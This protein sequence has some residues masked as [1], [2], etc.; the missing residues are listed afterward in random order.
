MN[1]F[2]LTAALALLAAP[3][4]LATGTAANTSISNQAFLDLNDGVNST[5]V[6]SNTVLVN[7]TQVYGLSITPDG[8]TTTPGQTTTAFPSTNAVLT[9]TVTNSGN[10]T[11]TLNLAASAANAAGGTGTVQ[12]VYVDT[13]GNGTY[14]P[15]TDSIATSVTLTAD[16]SKVVFILYTMPAATVAG[17]SYQ[18]NLTGTSAGDATKTDSNNVGQIIANRVVDLT[19]ISTQ[20]KTVAAGGSVSFTDTLTNTGNGPLTSAEVLLAVTQT[21]TDKNGVALTGTPFTVS[22]TATGPAGTFTNASAQSAVQSAIGAGGLPANG[23]VTLTPTVTATTTRVDGDKVNLNLKGYSGVAASATVQNNA[24]SGDAQATIDN[25][26]TVQRGTGIIGKTVA[27]CGASAA[28]CPNIASAGTA[29]ISARPGDFVVYYLTAQN[30]GSASL[31]AVK[32]RD[33]LPA[34]FIITGLG[35]KTANPGTLKYSR[36]GTS[37][38]TDP[39]TLGA[40][41]GGG[42]TVYVAIENGGSATTID[43][44]DTLAPGSTITVQI[45]GKVRDTPTVSG[46]PALNTSGL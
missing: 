14:D 24:P 25:L 4:T 7:V 30:T 12:G 22:Y 36:D 44:S 10:G 39:A 31:F 17:Q 6:P 23:T 37:W 33:A 21:A 27:F 5:P 28:S 40:L 11:D 46:T 9:Y 38:V 15:G 19:L 41:T 35:A 8:T 3:A 32:V 29:A 2:I 26:S 18:L 42:D 13:N 20:S 1:K 34:N 43:N 45:T 16:A